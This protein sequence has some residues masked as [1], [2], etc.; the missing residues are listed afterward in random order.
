MGISKSKD[1]ASGSGKSTPRSS[2]FFGVS[3]L[4]SRESVVKRFDSYSTIMAIPFFEDLTPTKAKNLAALFDRKVFAKDEVILREGM[5]LDQSFYVI[6]QGSVKLEAKKTVG[7]GDEKDGSVVKLADLTKGACFGTTAL[8]PSVSESKAM[9]V[10]A[11]ALQTDTILMYISKEKFAQ[12][13][14]EY[15]LFTAIKTDF[16]KTSIDQSGGKNPEPL[17]VLF[18]MRSLPF[19]SELDDYLLRQMGVLFEFRRYTQGETIFKQGEYLD[20]FCIVVKGL[21]EIV[22]EVP[23]KETKHFGVLYPSD[24]FGESSLVEQT[25]VLGTYK[26]RTDAVV[27]ILPTQKFEIFLSLA[28]HLMEHKHFIDLVKNRTSDA[29]KRI[30]IFSF[31]QTKQIGPLN[32]YDE[33]SLEVLA[34]MFQFVE[35]Q[36]GADIYKQGELPSAFY[37]IVQGSVE[38]WSEGE[39]HSGEEIIIEKL[40]DGD[41][42]GEIALINSEAKKSKTTEHV[43]AVDRTVILLLASSK[44]E[45]FRKLAPTVCIQI[46]QRLSIKTAEKLEKI[47]FFSGIKE[48]KPWS[49]IGLLGSMFKFESFESG[50]VVFQESDIG[51]KFYVI[52]DGKVSVTCKKSDSAESFELECL[53]N[54]QWFGEIS[55]LLKTP[56]T[57]SVTA[58]VPTLMLSLTSESF[59]KFLEIAPELND[60]FKTL[61][62]SRTA[63]TLKKFEFFRAVKE[64]KAWSKLEL[65]A[66]LMT[67]EVFESGQSVF[68]VDSIGDKFYI[69]AQGAVDVLVN[70]KEG[71]VKLDHLE[72]GSYFGEMALLSDESAKRAATVTTSKRTVLLSLTRECFQKFLKVAPELKPMIESKVLSRKENLKF[73]T[74][75]EEKAY[76][77]EKNEHLTLKDKETK[78]HK[79]MKVEIENDEYKE[80]TNTESL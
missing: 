13:A 61:V 71:Q 2:I 66:S 20:G 4:F 33:S 50:D 34:N 16:T 55:L 69:I 74:P 9:P 11:T 59:R 51:E 48:N 29:L 18:K 27:L 25:L 8:I 44:F 19:F 41:W 49:K 78:E 23:G 53:T 31:Y 10:T 26:A 30:P 3:Q 32:K 77:E 24:C 5:D 72:E 39:D 80:Q 58:V 63:N 28:P 79:E 12:F 47:P 45:D 17:S 43:K 22:S 67:Y 73:K 21:I 57:A 64:N 36:T 1:S 38:V 46:E 35:Y 76:N 40:S 75:E 60:P 42:F 37:I 62:N 52:V 6:I 15:D 56:R 68:T 65:L 70:S 54:G 7:N 14:Q